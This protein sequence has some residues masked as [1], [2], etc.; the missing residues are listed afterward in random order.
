[1]RFH[2]LALPHVELAEESLAC[3]YSMKIFKFVKMMGQ[4]GHECVT[5][6][7]AIAPP[8]VTEHVHIVDIPPIDHARLYDVDWTEGG[9]GAYNTAAIPAIAE[10][11]S[12]TDFLCITAGTAHQRVMDAFPNLISVESGIGYYGTCAKFRVFESHAWMHTVYERQKNDNGHWYDAV[13]PN[14]FDIEDFPSLPSPAPGD[15]LAWMGRFIER[16]GPHVA[17]QVAQAAGRQLLMAGQGV[18]DTQYTP[19]GVKIVGAELT[20]E[21]EGFEHIGPVGKIRRGEFLANAHALMMPTLYIEPFG[22][23]AVEALMCGTPVISTDWGAF[24]EFVIPGLTG[25]RFH[26]LKEAVKAVEDV[27]NLNRSYI[28]GYA[29]SRFG[30]E[31]VGRQYELY[32]GRLLDLWKDG[33]NQLD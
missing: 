9:F 7:G 13:I 32:F 6:G 25:Y 24:P 23:V 8:H 26:T 15:Y 21:G 19:E 27:S 16:K 11:A 1:M 10:R 5:Y 17:Y 3:A 22:G 33:W 12:G 2:V 30:L 4:L 20:M 31:T 14:Y 29:R 18:V 28:Q